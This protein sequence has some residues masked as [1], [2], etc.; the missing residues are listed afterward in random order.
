VVMP[1]GGAYQQS[2]QQPYQANEPY[3]APPPPPDNAG[4]WPGQGPP[5]P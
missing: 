1:P 5:T 2:Y 3:P 4:G